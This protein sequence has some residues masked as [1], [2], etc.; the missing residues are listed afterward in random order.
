MF[1]ANRQA[2]GRTEWNTGEGEGVG[3]RGEAQEEKGPDLTL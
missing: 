1:R 3:G 2:A